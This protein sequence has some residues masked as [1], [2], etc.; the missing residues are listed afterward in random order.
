VTSR[1]KQYGGEQKIWSRN[2]REGL[3]IHNRS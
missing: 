3:Q 2:K 1:E